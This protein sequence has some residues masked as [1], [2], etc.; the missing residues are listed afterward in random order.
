[1]SAQEQVKAARSDAL[2]ARAI[3]DALS[4]GQQRPAVRIPADWSKADAEST[5]AQLDAEWGEIMTKLARSAAE[6]AH[7][8]AE[9]VTARETIAKLQATLPMAQQREKDLDGLAKQGYAPAHMAQDKARERIEMERDLA[10]QQARLAESEAALHES[11]STRNAYIAETR[12]TLSD[13]EAQAELKY[14]QASQDQT[15]AVQREKLTVLI[16]P[17]AGV[18]QQLAVHTVGG[19]VTEAQ[20]LMV[21]VPEDAQVTAEVTLENKDVGFVSVGQEAEIKLETFLFTRYGTV[22]AVVTRVSADAVNDEKRGALFP[23]T[24]AL[25]TNAIDVDGKKVRLQPGM[26]LTAEI[27]TGRRRV[28]EYLLSP[29]Q[30]AGKESLRER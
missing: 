25:K 30:R 1:V 20:N 29:V 8:Q 16:A 13:R 28:I 2:R 26:N 5:R 12:R 21:I 4:G 9:I 15:K 14:Q 6:I 23:V 10:T 7:R 11:E 24:L 27:K 18:V 17:V 22:P 3:L 19:V